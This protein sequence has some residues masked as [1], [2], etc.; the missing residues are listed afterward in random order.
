M[1]SQGDAGGLWTGA[2]ARLELIL[3]PAFFIHLAVAVTWNI[4]SERTAAH[5]DCVIRKEEGL[6][7][8]S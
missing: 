6:F 7:V 1:L 4:A 5:A 3:V 2:I 8:S